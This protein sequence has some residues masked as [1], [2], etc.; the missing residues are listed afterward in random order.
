VTL[1]AV[2]AAARDV[3]ETAAAVLDKFDDDYWAAHCDERRHPAE[4]WQA[5]AAADLLG[6]GIPSS[7]GGAGAGVSEV[8]ALVEA[9]ARHRRPLFSLLTTFICGEL[10]RRHGSDAQREAW[11]PR[12]ADGSARF[13]FAITEPDAG[14]NSFAIRTSVRGDGDGTLRINGHK[15]YISGIDS[16]DV[17]VVVAKTPEAATGDRRDGMALLLVDPHAPGLTMRAMDI[18]M[19]APERQHDVWFDDVAVEPDAVVGELGSGFRSLFTVL[20]PERLLTAATQVGIGRL[21]LSL[22]VARA[23]ERAPFG[24]PVGSYQAIQHPLAHAHAQL[25][26]AEL[27]TYAGC[28]AYDAGESAGAAA[29]VAKLLAAEASQS[30]YDAAVQAHGGM[31]FDASA[32]LTKLWPLVRMGRIG[33]VSNEMV[34][35]HVA[36]QTL[37]LPKPY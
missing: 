37:G 33:P 8:A 14:T 24:V 7:Y 36:E 20:N 9:L 27:V 22:G 29:N 21:A 1:T 26:A 2:P 32:G 15:C 3:A 35:N 28:A 16:A 31:A 11:L 30:A 25:E 10:L 19:P 5:L 13:A 17:V 12:I 34:L 6:L 18:E 23:K 4:L